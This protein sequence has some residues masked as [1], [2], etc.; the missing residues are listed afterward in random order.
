MRRL[1]VLL[2]LFL[3]SSCDGDPAPAL[4]PGEELAGGD[5]TIRDESPNA[6]SYSARNMS[7]ERRQ[8]F[9]VGN[10]FFN[11]NWVIAPAS[12]TGRDGLGP[13]FNARS[14]SACHFKDG[15]GRPPEGDEAFAS[16]LMRLSVPGEGLHGGPRDVPGYGDQLQPNGID[17]VPGEAVP[18]VT[19]VE[20]PGSFA[21]G[22]TYSLR[23]PTYTLEDP[24]YGPL[25]PDLRVSPRVAPVMIGMGLLEAIP[26]ADILA[27]EDPD[28][29]DGDG[30]SGRANYVW[31]LATDAAVLGRFGWKANQPTVAQQ[32]AGAFLGDMGLTTAMFPLENC[33]EG[34]PDCAAA[35]NGGA[36][37]VAPDLLDD[38]IFYAA[39]LA[40]PARRDAG[41]PEVLRG[42]QVFADAG[43]ADCHVPR[44]VTAEDA[45]IEEVR[46]QTIWPY[47]DLLLH[48]LGDALADGRPDYLADGNEWRT[49]PLWGIGLVETVNGHTTFLHDG[50]ARSLMEAVL[51]HGGEAEPAREAVRAL[52]RDERDALI[53]FLESL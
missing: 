33:P 5:T 34:Q 40:V 1:P 36:P 52:P 46:G 4:E 21:D 44:H 42:K 17:G 27:R 10:S 35:P 45:A 26:A 32:T 6:F 37:E 23:A 20:Q 39:T 48:D 49:P 25:P 3:G 22:E 13:T 50:R 12:T 51:W 28:D 47:T 41:A 15:R 11:K 31:D 2:V 8:R 14:C 24:A 16:M 18:K 53:A 7:F 38:V 29:A 19:W 9:V 30:V 43:C